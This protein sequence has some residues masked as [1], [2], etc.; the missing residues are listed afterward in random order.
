VGVDSTIFSRSGGVVP[1]I[2]EEVSEPEVEEE[3]YMPI[4]PLFLGDFVETA[5]RELTS[6]KGET[7]TKPVSK[8]RVTRVPTGATK[9]EILRRLH[10][11][12]RW[13]YIGE[14]QVEDALV[15]LQGERRVWRVGQDR[16][17]L[18]L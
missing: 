10:R 6:T 3:G 17:E 5:I 4:T 16:W 18:T 11:D 15:Y 13:R 9:E 2:I 7:G 14:W 1:D 12:D 8:L